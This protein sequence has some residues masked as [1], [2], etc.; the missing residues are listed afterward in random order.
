MI[1]KTK[2]QKRVVELHKALPPITQKQEEWAREKIF[3]KIGYLRKKSI[4][5][6]ECGS[7]FKSSASLMVSL[8]GAKC[9]VCGTSLNI[10]TSNKRKYEKAFYY[11]IFTRKKEF[12]VLRHFVVTKVCKVGYPKEITIQE[13]VQ[14]WISPDGRLEN[15]AR[16]T[17]MSMYYDL[18]DYRS[19]MEV[20]GHS[21]ILGKYSIYSEYIYP[22]KQIIP[23]LR[24]NGFQGGL[25]GVSPYKLLPAILKN[26]KI[27]TL[28][29]AKQYSLLRL[30][31]NAGMEIDSYWPAIKI[32]IRNNYIIKPVNA[33]TWCDYIRM[34]ERLNKDIRNKHYVCP[35]NLKVEHDRYVE[36]V[37]RLN[38]REKAE[39]KRAKAE[40]YEKEYHEFIKRFED[41]SIRY[42]NIIV[43]PLRTV[44]EFI[45]ESEVMRHCLFSSDYHKKRKSLIMSARV[46]GKRTETVEFS[47]ETAQVVQSR[48]VENNNTDYHN[49][50]VDLVNSH[51]DMIIRKI[52]E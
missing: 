22:Y 8:T 1:P 9:P 11:T 43:E 16:P 5:C 44:N 14:N 41:I 2:L 26:S 40:K 27:E 37:R 7:R 18:W 49:Q 10:T 28:L 12:Q 35:T 31:V 33:S 24:R 19:P 42:K 36:K 13:C 45:K 50:I 48:G 47:L 21:V 17:F 6:L 38:D 23:E 52:A 25:H 3:D 51:S 29:K 4:W 46:D 20:R 15:I 30:F 32:C 34:L 39:E